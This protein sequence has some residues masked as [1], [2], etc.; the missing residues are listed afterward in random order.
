MTAYPEILTLAQP[1][2]FPRTHFA[3]A[4]HRHA[5]LLDD[6]L[7]TLASVVLSFFAADEA[8]WE[9]APVAGRI[10]LP[11]R[12]REA[13]VIVD[14][15]RNT[16][17]NLAR[18]RGVLDALRM[19]PPDGPGLYAVIEAFDIVSLHH[20]RAHLP[21]PGGDRAS[22][23][24][25]VVTRDIVVEPMQQ[26]HRVSRDSTATV[27]RWV[28]PQG[29]ARWSWVR[30]P[31]PPATPEELI[32]RL[33]S[34]Y[35]ARVAIALQEALDQKTVAD[36]YVL[37]SSTRSG[38]SL[39]VLDRSQLGTLPHSL[40]TMGTPGIERM[41]ATE[42]RA[43]LVPVCVRTTKVAGL[44]WIDRRH[45][46][47]EPHSAPSFTEPVQGLHIADSDRDADTPEEQDVAELAPRPSNPP[48]RADEPQL[49]LSDDELRGVLVSMS[50]WNGMDRIVMLANDDL[51]RE[52]TEAGF[53]PQIERAQGPGLREA[54]LDAIIE[55]RYASDPGRLEPST[56]QIES[57]QPGRITG[58]VSE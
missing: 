19:Q 44:R 17:A 35:D 34:H 56:H 6:M 43:G 8:L 39:L 20:L 27:T 28:T 9:I 10:V 31:Q 41:L 29:E 18:Y 25:Q 24:L 12:G 57:T 21:E 13:D 37:L 22:L 15:R 11:S 16:A 1:I 58:G 55:R 14:S 47:G 53:D 48:E 7:E 30:T 54:V 46:R 42:H 33:L 3:E 40:V 26:E 36:P 45:V 32:D 2:D 4:L 50:R 52:L 38:E 23:R 49:R 5:T 51:D